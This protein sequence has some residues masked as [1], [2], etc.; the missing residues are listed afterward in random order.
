[1]RLLRFAINLLQLYSATTLVCYNQR[2]CLLMA[3][4][5]SATIDPRRAVA[6]GI[7]G[8]FARALRTGDFGRGSSIGFALGAT[9]DLVFQ[10]MFAEIS[11][12]EAKSKMSKETQKMVALLGSAAVSFLVDKMLVPETKKQI[13]AQ[14]AVIDSIVGDRIGGVL[15]E[16]VPEAV[17][18]DGLALP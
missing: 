17:D 5:K 3:T 18:S 14:E 10:T 16:M 11:A 8:W 2:L 1:M 12:A 9:S 4:P 13:T 15:E 7:G 6:Y